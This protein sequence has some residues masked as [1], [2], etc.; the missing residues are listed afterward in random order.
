MTV[1]L[2]SAGFEKDLPFEMISNSLFE[3][4]HNLG[5]QPEKITSFELPSSGPSIFACGYSR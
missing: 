3:T 5:L 4:L 2:Q 1:Q